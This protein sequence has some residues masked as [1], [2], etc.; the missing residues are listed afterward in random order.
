MIIIYINVREIPKYYK[1]LNT[2]LNSLIKKVR[3]LPNNRI[4]IYIIKMFNHLNSLRPDLHISKF[5]IENNIISI[6]LSRLGDLEFENKLICNTLFNIIK[7][8]TNNIS[9]LNENEIENKFKIFKDDNIYKLFIDVM[10]F[11][12]KGKKELFIMFLNI[13][14]INNEQKDLHELNK[15]LFDFFTYLKDE[16]R[17]EDLL[18]ILYNLVIINDKYTFQRLYNFLGYPSL[19]IKQIPREKYNSFDD[20][21]DK[22]NNFNEKIKQKWPIFGEKLIN[23]NINNHIYEYLSSNHIKNYFCLLSLLFPK[24]SVD[25]ENNNKINDNIDKIIISDKIKNKILINLLNECFGDKKNYALFKYIYLMPARTLLYKNLYEEILSILKEDNDFNYDKIKEREEKYIKNIEKEVN[26]TNNLF[27][28]ENNIQ[29]NN[30]HFEEDNIIEEEN[31]YKCYDEKIKDYI[32]FNS[33]IIPG[34]IVKESIELI[35]KNSRQGMYRADY[36]TKYYKF[37]ELRNNLLNNKYKEKEENTE[38]EEKESEDEELLQE[39]KNYDVSEKNENSIIYSKLSN[40]T[41]IV[42]EDKSLKNK[43]KV[44]KTLISFFFVNTDDKLN[45]KLD[46]NIKLKNGSLERITNFKDNRIIDYSEHNSIVKF[47]SIYRLRD[48]LPFFKKDDI[49]ILIDLN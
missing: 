14:E 1:Q 5:L 2:I 16:N 33:D 22:Q 35:A 20:E 28:I 18:D 39:Y 17:I 6:L 45:K 15:K 25:K 11:I 42:L 34:E 38:N 10:G 48:D 24:D 31:I 3:D 8:Y 41:K 29:N 12:F 44:Q 23:G 36:F 13:F 9:E 47:Y 26:I 27:N 32:G 4:I 30:Y 49:S 21:I 7:K 46:I 43:N 40:N 37:D 19:I